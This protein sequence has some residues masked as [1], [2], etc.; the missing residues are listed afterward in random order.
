MIFRSSRPVFFRALVEDLQ[1][2]SLPVLKS[3]FEAA[4]LGHK[5]GTIIAEREEIIQRLAPAPIADLSRVCSLTS[6]FCLPEQGMTGFEVLSQASAIAVQLDDD[7]HCPVFLSSCHVMMPWKWRNYYP[8]P[9]IEFLRPEATRY[10]IE[11]RDAYSGVIL[12]THELD[13]DTLRAHPSRDVAAI[14]LDANAVDAYT[15]SGHALNPVVLSPEP[16]GFDTEVTVAGHSIVEDD[17]EEG[18][19]QLRVQLPDAQHGCNLVTRTEMQAF[20][21]T[22]H[23]LTEGMC[24]GGLF[25]ENVCYGVVEGIVPRTVPALAGCAAFIES[26]ELRTWLGSGVE[27][28]FP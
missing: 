21:K 25:D 12:S 23:V 10:S 16:L 5:L 8:Q 13:R 14:S 3:R 24:G 2:L 20:L 26:P 7:G 28:A 4:G 17:L 9:W 1:G 18:S 22:K 19:T 27:D 6:W 15:A 11:V